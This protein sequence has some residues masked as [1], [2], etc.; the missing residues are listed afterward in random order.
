MK[1]IVYFLFIILATKSFKAQD[2]YMN[3][4]NGTT[5]TTCRGNFMPSWP[6]GC[7]AFGYSG[8]CNNEN[9]TVTFYSGNPL[10]PLN[11]S[12]LPLAIAGF[13][14]NDCFYTEA[15]FDRLTIING[16]SIGSP[17]L[18]VLSGV[19]ASPISYSTTG[20][21][22]TINFISDGIINDWGWF[23]LLGC[24][25]QGCNGNLPASDICAN[26][27]AICDLNGY[28]GS[29]NGWYTPDNFT[30]LGSNYSGPF[31]GSIENNSWIK[32]IPN[33]TN[34]SINVL[35][36]NCSSPTQ[37]I[38]AAIM[39]SS[40]CTSF[41]VLACQSQ[42]A[43]PGLMTLNYSSFI[44]GTTYY[45][46]IDGYA[47]NACDYT[48]TANTGIAVSSINASS[49]TI[50]NG[51]STNLIAISPGSSPSFA[52]NTGA[53]SAGITV[54]PALTT[55]YTATISSGFC[56]EIV[57][58]TITVNP[59]PTANAGASPG[60]ITCSNPTQ[61]LSGSG[62]GSYSW[63]GTGII[64]GGSSANPVVNGTGPY[65]L[66]VTV[67]GCT[68][69]NVAS[70]TNVIN[71]L[72]P[73]PSTIAPNAIT[74]GTPNVN[75]AIS[76]TVGMS[77]S[78]TGPNVISGGNTA[79][80]L[81]NASGNY[82]VLVTNTS[83]GCT[84]NAVINIQSSSGVTVAPSTSGNVTCTNPLINLSTTN[85]VGQTY[86]WTAP[87]GAAI[88]SGVNSA[89]ATG[90]NSGTYTVT[91]VNTSNGCLQIATIVANVNIVAPT[92]TAS[93]SGVITCTSTAINLNVNP[94][95]LNYSWSATGG[96]II[97]GGALTQNATGSGNGNYIVIVTNPANGC[98]VTQTITPAVNTNII[99]ASINAP[100]PLMCNTT[101]VSLTANPSTGV[102]YLWTAP[103]GTNIVTANNLQTIG[104]NAPGTY[105]LNL[106]N[107]AN[108][109]PSAPTTIN[110]TQT[111]TQPVLSAATQTAYKGCGTAN[112]LLTGTATP[113][114]TTYN[115]TSSGGGFAG[116]QTNNFALVTSTTIYTLTA[117]HPVTGCSSFLT[118]TVIPDLNSPVPNLTS[119]SAVITCVNT[120]FTTTGVV[121]PAAG[122]TYT[123]TGPG[124][125]GATNN[126]A[127]TANAAG[128]YTLAVTQTSNGCTGN[129]NYVITA[130]NAPVTPTANITNILTC[131]STNATISA[132]AT[133]AG[134]FTYLWSG[135]SSFASTSPNFVTT[136][137]GVY[138]VTITNTSNQCTGITNVSAIGNFTAPST[139]VIAVNDITLTC[140]S[141][142]ST[143]TANS[144]G[145]SSYSWTSPGTGAITSGSNSATVNVTGTGI[146]TVVAIGANGCNTAFF[147]ITATISPAAGAPASFLNTNSLV[148][149]C[150]VPNPTASVTTTVT[151]VT[152]SW[153]SSTGSGIVGSAISPTVAFTQAGTYS[154]VVTNTVNGC[155]TPL[156]SLIVTVTPG[157]FQ[158]TATITSAP[159]LNCTN[160]VVTISPNF[161]P[162][163]GLVYNWTG[164]NIV[165][166]TTN[167]AIQTTSNTILTLSYTNTANG[168]ANSFTVAAI[169]NGSAPT[170]TLSSATGFNNISCQT[171]TLS[172]TAQVTPTSGVSYLWSNGATT[173]TMNAVIAGIYSVVATN[174]ANGCQIVQSFTVGGAT[175]APT[176]T[177]ASSGLIPCGSTTTNLSASTTNSNVSFIWSGIGILNGAT[178]PSP[179]IGGIGTYTLYVIDNVSQCSITQT[180]SVSTS[181]VFAQFTANP[182]TGPA[183]LT[184]NF[185]NQSLGATSYDW[186][187]GN[188]TSSQTNPSNIYANNGS[189]T[190][191]LTAIN[192]PC[193]STAS[194]VIEVLEGLG[195]I[196][197]VFT[198]N[199]DLYN[200]TFEIKGLDAYQKNSLQVFNRWGNLIFSAKPY[201]NDW[202]GAA[203]V[204]GKTGG[205]KLPTGTYYYIL[206]LGDD[207]KTIY[208]GYVQLQY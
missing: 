168:C 182:L 163:T 161:S 92:A 107:T 111:L 73:S 171:P 98:S 185:T 195:V 23:A 31:C 160:T 183:P 76:P 154:V 194:I 45:I 105:T 51:Q 49:S 193:T 60:N 34:A 124:I 152:Y 149:T 90:S 137:Q 203:N 131:S 80:A 173:A 205:D 144:T 28:C 103:S 202:T 79:S 127:I 113:A 71:T 97:T 55:V 112:V 58:R 138:T 96:A 54:S 129:T 84:A 187:F 63:S 207:T 89:V 62:G 206:D 75:V 37:G 26:S 57:T 41:G 176:Y 108:G 102:S 44:P 140:A 119:N 100:A 197:E 87:S 184:V 11:I 150:S 24:R 139:P 109:C 128:V 42:A 116:L 106:I 115:W 141:N 7:S 155:S 9:R 118:F 25:P 145:A 40:N 53:T 142:A 8:Y 67:A 93:T 99:S 68:S 159:S 59:I 200:P 36:N 94:S 175:T 156:N 146:F 77:Y 125:V 61:V 151:G 91:V 179:I 95:G 120:V 170:L 30:T 50:C 12:F 35:S 172:Y 147:P 6:L 204:A 66:A 3:A 56:T 133:G 48:V 85:I 208:K 174:T 158:P 86:T 74:C 13:P 122:I 136:N 169:S 126:A 188:G 153:T 69:T 38:Q 10:I 104:V 177:A 88:T 18:A 191:V 22:M 148:I 162:S 132:N 78:W 189:F 21:Y 201:R 33:S 39:N 123:W 83:N 2:Y 32:F 82:N 180:V 70:V 43:G 121:T 134:P 117:T 72:V 46:M 167:S 130:N 17:T 19:I 157:N 135:P 5:V 81:V 29:T 4:V 15:G 1:K 101:T 181:T 16:P 27:P 47:G 164:A 114:G 166:S 190:V 64:S 20:A 14:T 143:L 196:P 165:G 178:T 65:N 199:G 192:G 110:V 186:N 198:P 52:W